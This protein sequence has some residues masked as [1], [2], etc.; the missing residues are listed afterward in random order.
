V[1]S[2]A[3]GHPKKIIAEKF[4]TFVEKQ[5]T[6]L[7]KGNTPLEKLLMSQMLTREV[8]EHSS[9]SP[10]ARAVKRLLAAGINKMYRTYA[11][12]I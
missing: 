3:G 8:G 5:L 10:A 2:Q 4:L 9:P 6:V 11:K 12:V 7:R 1:I